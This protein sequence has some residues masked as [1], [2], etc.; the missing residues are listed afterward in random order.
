METRTYIT[1]SEEDLKKLYPDV[2]CSDLNDV[3]EL[4]DQDHRR[5][6]WNLSVRVMVNT[7]TA[8]EVILLAEN[9]DPDVADAELP[10]G[11]VSICGADG[12]DV[13]WCAMAGYLLLMDQTGLIQRLTDDCV[14][15]D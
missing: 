3:A 6:G 10:Y 11:K 7:H 8:W 15:C 12:S 5:T 13:P 14:L 1:V 9:P 4:M 2:V